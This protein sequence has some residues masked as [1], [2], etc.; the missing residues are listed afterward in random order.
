MK[1]KNLIKEL[2]KHNSEAHVTILDAP[3]APYFGPECIPV[4]KLC[5]KKGQK[6]KRI[7]GK[8]LAW[9]VRDAENPIDDIIVLM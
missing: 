7:F 2:S 6:S 1:V 3:L 8:T 9:K 5:I 4:R